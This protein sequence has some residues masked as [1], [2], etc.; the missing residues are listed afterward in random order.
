MVMIDDD[1][2]GE[3]GDDDDGK[4]GGN[5]VA[6]IGL[7]WAISH[8]DDDNDGDNGDDDNDDED[9]D[10]FLATTPFLYFFLDPFIR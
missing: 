6:G 5:D 1:N 9:G 7:G 3:D 8:G 10:V 2:D 4:D